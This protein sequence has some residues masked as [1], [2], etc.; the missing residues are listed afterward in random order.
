V[1]AIETADLAAF[2]S[3]DLRALTTAQVRALTSDQVAA[4]ETDQLA[5]LTTAQVAALD[6]ADIVALGTDGIGALTSVQLAALST[7]Q[8]AAITTEQFAS[9]SSD[10]IAAL[11]TAQAAALTTDQIVAFTTDQIAGLESRDIAAMS[12]TQMA[13]FE[14]E[15]IAMMD[16][17]QLDAFLMA[18]PIVLDLDGN[19]IRTVSAAEGVQFDLNATGNSAQVGWVGAGDG[20]LVRDRNGDGVINDGRELY[21]VATLNA[22]GQRSGNGYAAMATEDSNGDGKLS[23]A[24]ANFGELRVWVDGNQDG[25]TDAGE[26]QGLVD[27]GITEIDL[28]YA[29]TSEMNNGNYVGMVSSYTTADGQTREVADVWFAKDAPTADELLAAAPAELLG[30]GSATGGTAVATGTA[31]VSNAAL[32]SVLDDEANRNTPLV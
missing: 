21:G 12:A 5:A 26:L 30:G 11:S 4:L 1:A 19:G 27:L 9:L 22:N 20:L 31:A 8:Y 2:D 15:D 17:A 18:S 25:K 29:V 32:R 23:A 28:N 14:T 6:T 7:T 3:A 10:D 24:D 13:A 16:G